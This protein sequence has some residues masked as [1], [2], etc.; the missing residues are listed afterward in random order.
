M[1][2]YSKLFLYIIKKDS[3]LYLF[4]NFKSLNKITDSF[5][6]GLS[7]ALKDK[8]NLKSLNLNL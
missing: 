2:F 3:K 6:E 8:V 1:G 5:G 7:D 4:I